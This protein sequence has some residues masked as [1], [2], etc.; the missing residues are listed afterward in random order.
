MSIGVSPADD[1]CENG[2]V[3]PVSRGNVNRLGEIF[4][5][6]RVAPSQV[7]IREEEEQSGI[8]LKGQKRRPA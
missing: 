6:A 1:K 2:R 5:I 8:K 3:R 7:L 4:M